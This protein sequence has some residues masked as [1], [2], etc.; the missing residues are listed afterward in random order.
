MVFSRPD[1]PAMNFDEV[2]I[3][4]SKRFVK[5]LVLDNLKDYAAKALVNTVD[6]L[7]TA[8]HK[9][10]DLLEQQMLQ[11]S[12]MELKAYCLNHQLL[13]CQTYTDKEGLGEQQV[14]AFIPR[15]HK[16]YTLPDY[17]NKKL[18]SIQHVQTNPRQKYFL[19]KSL[20]QPSDT[21][22]SKPLSW[23][24][25]LDTN[26][27]LKGTSQTLASSYFH[28][29]TRALDDKTCIVTVILAENGDSRN[30]KSSATAF[31][32]SPAFIP[33]LGITHGELEGSI[34]L[35][36]FGLKSFHNQKRENISAPVM[37]KNIAFEYQVSLVYFA[38]FNASTDV[39][40]G[41]PD[42]LF[43]DGQKKLHSS[44]ESLVSA[45]EW[46][47][48]PSSV[49]FKKHKPATVSD[50]VRRRHQGSCKTG[51][52]VI[53]EQDK[54]IT[55]LVEYMINGMFNDINSG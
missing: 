21:P 40:L 23:H 54:Y 19:A 17:V 31:P 30:K 49:F 27:T 20:L 32:A 39:F 1:D 22:A 45:P 7:G 24:L 38:P 25:A 37:G 33:T 34:P 53:A 8:A 10:T 52:K 28:H 41:S 42:F 18:L 13:I 5:A 11:V 14:L 48:F 43:G 15:H 6:H 44:S 55:Q 16:H 12:T 9:L 36:A 46:V 29:Y 2:S 47:T 3:E 35:T 50:E 51:C 26:S 4:H